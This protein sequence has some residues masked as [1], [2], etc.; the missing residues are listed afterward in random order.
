MKSLKNLNKKTIRKTK[1]VNKLS[2]KKKTKIVNKVKTIKK[3]KKIQKGGNP[4]FLEVPNKEGNEAQIYCIA[5]SCDR[6]KLAT[7]SS[8]KILHIWDMLTKPPQIEKEIKTDNDE[9]WNSN[10]GKV[11]K[12]RHTH[13]I[14][15]LAWSPT[16]MVLASAS[17]EKKVVLWNFK[18]SSNPENSVILE[19]ESGVMSIAWSLTG[20]LLACG[21]EN[22]NI[23]L[24]DVS[25][26]QNN[27]Y[28]YH[29]K[30]VCSLAWFPVIDYGS[31]LTSADNENIYLIKIM[32]GNS[33]ATPF[34]HIERPDY[35]ISFISWM[36]EKML[37]TSICNGKII[38]WILSIENNVF[39]LVQQKDI[40]ELA[41]SI[42][43][44]AW[45]PQKN[46]SIL[47]FA[48]ES[49]LID[50]WDFDTKI[51]YQI[52]LDT[53]VSVINSIDWSPNGEY[54]AS[55]NSNMMVQI[56]KKNEIPIFYNPTK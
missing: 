26:K 44:L 14:S 22:G 17:G 32:N 50:V 53:S 37:L 52:E 5:W 16:E 29:T 20:T 8:D 28:K 12:T 18:D 6:T 54:L 27:I 46:K 51:E 36:P 40:I 38:F 49:N 7:S 31:I 42:K 30:A 47:A 45:C 55:T 2:I 43:T 15:S 35:K 25:L 9:F 3:S 13:I 39:Q 23:Y 24:W 1:I 41:Y 56:D 21:C 48:G 10:Y 34:I 19:H 11:I 33:S 4:I